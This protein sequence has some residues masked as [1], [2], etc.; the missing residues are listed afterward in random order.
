MASMLIDS[1]KYLDFFKSDSI[2]ALIPV[3]SNLR[4]SVLVT[5]QIVDE[6]NRNKGAVFLEAMRQALSTPKWKVPTPLL[7]SDADTTQLIA[8]LQAFDNKAEALRR[9]IAT[10]FTELSVQIAESRDH[11][12]TALEK[13]F[14][15]PVKPTLDQVKRARLRKDTGNPPGKHSDPIGDELTWEQFL[16]A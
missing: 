1:N 15:K 5:E 14:G 3:L 16:D 9:R 11:I 13:F 8:D 12:S 7:P 4:S 10:R 6:V 2:A